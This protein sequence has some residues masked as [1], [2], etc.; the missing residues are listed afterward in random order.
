MPEDILNLPGTGT[1]SGHLVYSNY[2]Y[3]N[4]I[5]QQ[6][7]I[8]HPKNLIIDILRKYFSSDNRYPYRADEYGYPLTPDISGLENTEYTGVLIS[9]VFRYEVK[10]FP[11]ILVKSNGGAYKPISFNQEGTLKYRKDLLEDE[12]TG[13]KTIVS[14]PTHRVYAGMWDMRFDVTIYTESHAESEELTEIVS[15]LLQH[16]AWN[17]LR[18][19][20][21]FIKSLSISAQ[22]NEPY[23]NDY[24]YSHT[25]SIDTMSEWRVEIPIDSVIEKMIFYFD[26]VKTPTSNQALVGLATEK[27]KDIVDMAEIKL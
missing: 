1:N 12:L 22:N 11:A 5:I 20:G 19:S 16:T 14:T 24:I 4:H 2:Y 6:V 10:F 3:D 21:L 27:F 17:E 25:I 18:A 13:R 23:A 15:L 7:C 9:D 8:V 26:S